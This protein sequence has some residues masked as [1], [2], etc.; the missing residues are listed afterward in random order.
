MTEVIPAGTWRERA[1]SFKDAG[2]WLVSLCGLDR[3]RL[4]GAGDDRFHVVVHFLHTERKERLRM[5]VVAEGDP[6]T[7]PTVTDL[8]PTAVV[9]EREAYDLY[10]IHFD[11]HRDLHRI[12]M[13]DEW[14][15]HPLRKDYGVG[16][17]AID[18]LPQPLVQIDAPHQSPKPTEAEAEVDRLGQFDDHGDERP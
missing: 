12:L 1:Q 16:K 14:E 2:W 17:I 5:H 10:G 15:G 8:V 18:F 7:V 3:L 4:P 6:P 11:G 9:M 13:P